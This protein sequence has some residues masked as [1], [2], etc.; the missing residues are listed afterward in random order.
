MADSRIRVQLV[1]VPAVWGSA[2]A[3]RYRWRNSSPTRQMVPPTPKA[4]RQSFPMGEGGPARLT[5]RAYS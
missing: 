1:R 5:R 2:P 4:H 3:A